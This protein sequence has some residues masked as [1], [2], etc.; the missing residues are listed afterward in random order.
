M[1]DDNKDYIQHSATLQHVSHHLPRYL[2]HCPIIPAIH[3][4]LDRGIQGACMR[5]V[6]S[7]QATVCEPSGNAKGTQYA[8]F[9]DG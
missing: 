4:L 9:E 1:K 5:L 6:T 3:R 2:L 8:G 7:V